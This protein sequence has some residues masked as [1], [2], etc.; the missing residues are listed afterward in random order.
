MRVYPTAAQAAVLVRL[1]GAA[2]FVW[3]W[4]LATRTAAWREREELLSWVALS[5][6]FTELRREQATAWL[7][8]LPR[9]PFN[10]VLR[11]QERAF[12]NFFSKRAKYPT[13]KRRG[14]H[15]SVR[16]TLDQRR[17]Q[18]TQGAGR[19]AT[20]DLPGLG[21]IKLRQIEPLSGRLRSVTLSRDGSGRHFASITADGVAAPVS[22]AASHEAVGLDAGL[23]DLLVIAG[24]TGSLRRVAAPRALAAKLDKLRR[25]QRRQSRQLEAQM[26]VQGLDPAKPC[27]KGVRLGVSGRRRRQQQKIARLYAAI[28]D[29]RRDALH[30]ATTTVV[31]TAAVIC[32]E[33]LNLKAMSRGM[34]RRGFRRSVNDAALGEVRRQLTYK[35]AWHGRAVSVVDRFYPSSKT[36]SACGTINRALQLREKRW[37]CACGAEHDRDEN[38]ATNIRAEG[39]RLLRDV[40]ASPATPRSGESHARGVV[41]AVDQ[42]QCIAADQHRPTKNRELADAVSSEKAARLKRATRPNK[43]RMERVEVWSG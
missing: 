18:V 25:Y 32:V 34:G 2:R 26:R 19:F 4:A 28:G 42:R 24:D 1:F 11:N 29:V 8:E 7:A 5:R 41:S 21:Q 10:Q 3:N 38:A 12:A 37:T 15:A 40:C 9:E 43:T 6:Q 35:S 23:R 27:P 30:Q 33:D 31:R 36:C 14:G 39:L 17:V 22:V 16:F 13:F 20:V